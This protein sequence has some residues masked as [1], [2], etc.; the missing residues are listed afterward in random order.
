MGQRYYPPLT[1][2]EVVAVLKQLGFEFKVQHGSHAQY[3]HAAKSKIP[4]SVVTV[5][6]AEDEF[7]DFLM[8]SMVR[9]S[10][11]SREEFYGAT[12]RSAK[13]ASVPFTKVR[14]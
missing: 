11:R 12:K 14:Q 13:N 9:Q 2:A 8:S 1:P 10:N 3:E 5:D 4:R 6:M 7:G